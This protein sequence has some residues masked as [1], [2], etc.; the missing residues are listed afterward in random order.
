MVGKTTLERIGA[1]AV[2][3]VCDQA[4]KEL[5]AAVESAMRGDGSGV[6]PHLREAHGMLSELLDGMPDG[7]PGG[8]G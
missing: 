1:L 5:R 3:R 2:Q 8:S 6:G 7:Q 4:A